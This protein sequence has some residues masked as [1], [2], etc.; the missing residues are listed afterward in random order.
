[1]NGLHLG[2]SGDDVKGEQVLLMSDYR[3]TIDVAEDMVE[4]LERADYELAT[5]R[6]N[7]AYMADKFRDEEGL[8]DFP[9]MKSLFDKE[10]KKRKVFEELKR[11]AE[12]TYVPGRL[13]DGG[14]YEWVIDYRR[15]LMTVT[16]HG[17]TE[18]DYGTIAAS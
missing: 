17:M 16:V 1:M 18:E 6:D 14:H 5:V 12:R 2:Q 3:L 4:A 9:V 15:K 10:I 11:E 8:L 7:Y 13:L